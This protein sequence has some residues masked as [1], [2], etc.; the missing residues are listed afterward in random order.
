MPF[1]PAPL[2]G[3]KPAASPQEEPA[4]ATGSPVAAARS[5]SSAIAQPL[6]SPPQ[7]AGVP[8]RSRI[9]GAPA[10]QEKLNAAMKVLLDPTAHAL[11]SRVYSGQRRDWNR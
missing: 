7:G 1:V 9:D 2:T 8:R 4:S 3:N 11:A 6:P 10:G 5:A